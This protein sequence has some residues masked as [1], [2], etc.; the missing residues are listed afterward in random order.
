MSKCAAAREYRRVHRYN[1]EAVLDRARVRMK[2]WPQAMA[3]RQR[4]VEH[5]FGSIKYWMG[6]RDFL[7]RRLPNVRAEFS[8]TAL[9]F[10]IRRAITLI[11]VWG[12]IRRLLFDQFYGYLAIWARYTAAFLHGLGRYLIHPTQNGAKTHQ[13]TKSLA[14]ILA[15]ANSLFTRLD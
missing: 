12:V 6:H 1:N 5:P 9:T 7:T 14:R 4:T 11:G 13:N 3:S 2:V 8:L 10:N 15:L